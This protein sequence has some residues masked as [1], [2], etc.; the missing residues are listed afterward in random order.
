M[1]VSITVESTTTF[2]NGTKKLKH[3]ILT[4]PDPATLVELWKLMRAAEKEQVTT[5]DHV[6]MKHKLTE[7]VSVNLSTENMTAMLHSIGVKD[8][9]STV[10]SKK[11]LQHN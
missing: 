5:T 7:D 2:P 1:S 11:A 3:T 10:K 6:P 8:E 4:A 9:D